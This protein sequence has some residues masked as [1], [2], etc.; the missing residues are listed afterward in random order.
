MPT[1]QK[2]GDT[3]RITVSNGYDAKGK[4]LRK[5]MTWQ[6]APG[7]TQ[8]QIEKEL[9]RQAVLF[10]NKSGQY[11]EGNIKFQDFAERWFEDYGKEH[12]R[13]RTYLRYVELSQRTYAAIGHIRLDRLQ[14]HHLLDFYKQLAEPGQ[15]K[16]TGGGLAPKTIK[17]YHTFISSVMERAVKWKLI[18]DN[19]GRAQ[20]R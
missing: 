17:H 14:P 6:P 7:M 8:K 16:R 9:D 20:S 2:R 10:E 4:Q 15:N 19:P 1:I 5:S 12:L 3:Y 18:A 13:E 11:M